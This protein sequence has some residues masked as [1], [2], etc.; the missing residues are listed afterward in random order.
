[1][2]V[3]VQGQTVVTSGTV[4]LA[5]IAIAANQSGGYITNP[6]SAAD[7]G[8]AVAE[9]L[10]VD[11]VQNAHN[12]AGGTTSELR[13]GQTFYIIPYSATP[14]TVTSKTANHNFTAVQ[15]P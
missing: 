2:A 11:P 13:P 14:V 4:G 3:P 5:V 9:S 7:Q 12:A 1:M 10:Y 15:W 6:S 8:V